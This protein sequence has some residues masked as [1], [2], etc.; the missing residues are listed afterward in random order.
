MILLKSEARNR[1]NDGGILRTQFSVWVVLWKADEEDKFFGK[2]MRAD[3]WP[4]ENWGTSKFGSWAAATCFGS[5]SQRTV[6]G[7]GLA[8]I[9]SQAI[10]RRLFEETFK[11]RW[12]CGF[13]TNWW[14]VRF[15]VALFTTG[16]VVLEN[17][18]PGENAGQFLKIKK[19]PNSAFQL[20]SPETRSRSYS[21]CSC[22]SI[23]DGSR[24]ALVDGSGLFKF[25]TQKFWVL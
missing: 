9:I 13:S 20:T 15:R 25:L 2:T 22:P 5:R 24:C 16:A 4:E 12:E 14:E 6:A 18:F 17:V 11:R 10:S 23:I 21:F 8:E 1:M 7:R 19:T 3:L